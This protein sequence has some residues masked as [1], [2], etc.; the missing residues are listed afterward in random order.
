MLNIIIFGAPGAGK[1]TQA[2]KLAQALNLKHISTGLLLREE[3]EKQSAIGKKVASI[4]KQGSLVADEIVDEIVK[5]KILENGHQAGF[6]FDGYPRTL[7]QA[8]NLDHFM[9][10]Y[11]LPTILNLQVNIDNLVKRLLLRGQDSNRP[12]DNELTIKFRMS[13]YTEQTEPLLKFYQSENRVF[14]IDGEASVEDVYTNLISTCKSI[15]Q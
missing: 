1:G 14:H 15:R 7:N 11:G 2:Q 9:R 12:D 3:V 5:N 13:I 4:I 8:K 6:I 10:N